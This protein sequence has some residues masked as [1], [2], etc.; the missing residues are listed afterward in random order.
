MVVNGRSVH[1]WLVLLACCLATGCGGSEPAAKTGAEGS[2]TTASSTKP[3]GAEAGEKTAAAVGTE[4]STA[5]A[6]TGT[7]GRRYTIAVIPK[8]T[9]HEFWKSVHFGAEQ[10][11]KEFGNV[12]IIW[13]GSQMENDRTG[14]IAVVRDFITQRVDGICLA[15]LDS[16]ALVPYVAEAKAENIPT[17]VFD[18]GLDDVSNVVSYVATDNTKG[19]ELAADQ[20]GK[21]LDGTGN[22]ILLRYS[23]GSESTH[24]R[25]EGFLTRL[26][27]KFPNIK[28]ISS[29]QYSDTTPQGSFDRCRQLFLQFR[30]D[31]NGC[32]AVCEPNATGML[33]A[34]QEEQLAGTVKFVGFDPAPSLI[35]S[36]SNGQMQGIVLQDPV[37][38]GY[39]SVKTIVDHL[40]GVAV[41]KT[42]STGEYIATPDNLTDARIQELLSPK[43][44]GE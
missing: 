24:Q 1:R 2:K 13:K 16:A 42:I 39:L 28:V 26:A 19:G 29:D 35:E 30:Q 41:E 5:D 15:P 36:L 11:A 18:S 17:V 10:A 8:G 21:V 23:K 27:E 3:G 4:K 9:T 6:E 32:F 14:Q 37:R 7:K 33:R 44:F 38:M 20:L 34:L 22:V 12:D 31:V 43:M 40:N 25:E